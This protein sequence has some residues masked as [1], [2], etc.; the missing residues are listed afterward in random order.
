MPGRFKTKAYSAAQEGEFKL[1]IIDILN[2]SDEAMTIDDI[3]SED[4]ILRDLTS[5]KMSRVLS[6]LIELGLVR[7]A[8]SKAQGR[9][10]YKAV[11]KMIEQGYDMGESFPIAN[12]MREWTGVDWEL[13]EEINSKYCT[14]Y[15]ED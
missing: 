13:E 3:K 4:I 12:Q 2:N 1:R 7:K 5:Q 10:V 11:S 15:D 6:N 9:M 8:R 14:E